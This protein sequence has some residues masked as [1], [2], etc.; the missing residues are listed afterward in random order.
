MEEGSLRCDANIS[1]RDFSQKEFGEK[2]EIKNLNSFKAVREALIFE[3]H[4]QAEYLD[5]KRKIIQETRLWDEKKLATVSMREK[6][7][8]HDYRYFPEPD[9]VPFEI[10]VNIIEKI[11]M[12]MPE[13]PQEK[14]KRFAIEY[15]LKPVDIEI[16]TEKKD[17]ACFYEEVVKH[18]PSHQTVCNWVKGEVMR[19]I[20]EKNNDIR[21]LAL[22][23][24]SLAE[25]VEMVDKGI[26][27]GLA[28]KEVLEICT[29][30]SLSPKNIVKDRGLEQVSDTG[31][32]DNIIN[33]VI[34]ENE[35][36]VNDYRNGKSNALSF[37]VGQVMKKSKGKANPK[38]AGDLLKAKLG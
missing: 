23:P 38:V 26:I 8:S 27:S 29:T 10:D 21:S 18:Y 20:K 2:V 7:N 5:E 36:S 13:L 1:L 19:Q 22:P 17:I 9:L 4:R 34:R 11:R 37:L 35:K 24:E 16:L 3:E 14:R 32:L 6:E 15:S 33:E 31:E 30:T 12:T 25:I 28:G